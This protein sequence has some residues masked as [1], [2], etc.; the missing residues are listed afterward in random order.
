MQGTRTGGQSGGGGSALARARTRRGC[1]HGAGSRP[2]FLRYADHRREISVQARPAVL[3][4]RRIRRH[5]QGR[6]TG[7][8]RNPAG[9]PGHGLLRLG[10]GAR[11][12]RGGG[13]HACPDSAF[14]LLRGGGRA[15]RHLRH[16]LPCAPRPG[17]ASHRRRR[18]R[19]SGP[20]EGSARRQSSS[21]RRW[22]RGSSPVPRR[23]TSSPSAAR[24]GRM[25]LSIIRQH[26]ARLPEGADGRPRAWTWST[27]RSGEPCRRRR[28]GPPP[29]RGGS[30]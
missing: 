30:W 18:W 20:R 22:A 14:D 3:A 9:G 8:G 29:G 11:G 15:H 16:D 23:R 24:S 5:G 25:Q 12:D 26:A 1:G 7:G 2:Q 19:C 21:A 27:T 17:A 6:R 4:G 28:C 13:K 10:G